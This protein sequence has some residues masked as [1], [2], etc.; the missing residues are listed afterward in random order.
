MGHPGLYCLALLVSVQ[1]L[2]ECRVASTGSSTQVG[3]I[4]LAITTDTIARCDRGLTNAGIYAVLEYRYLRDSPR[5]ERVDVIHIP[6]SEST[7]CQHNFTFN[8]T[9]ED[10][11]DPSDPGEL[12]V[13][14]RL[15]QWEHGGGFC[16]CWG[17]VRG[18]FWVHTAQ[19]SIPITQQ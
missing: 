19:H 2:V 15:L 6:T 3:S 4:S 1:C 9:Y 5:W 13:Q 10:P 16:N 18:S 8:F 7:L 14:F 17:V 11:S 12:L